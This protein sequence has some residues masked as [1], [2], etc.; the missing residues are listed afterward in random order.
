MINVFKFNKN[1]GVTL[2][3]LMVTM[4]IL[5]LLLSIAYPSYSSY[6]TKTHR[7]EAQQ[8]LYI[9]AKDMEQ[10][11]AQNQ[12]Y[13]GASIVTISHVKTI[14]NDYYHFK[15]RELTEQSYQLAAIPKNGRDKK[16]GT[17]TL[18]QLGEENIT[19]TSKYSDCWLT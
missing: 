16:C 12:S 8:T 1:T 17:L 3:E 9:L 4:A 13:T 19:G 5:G 6:L 15:I 14:K 2:I 11:H 7:V 10:Y 18:D